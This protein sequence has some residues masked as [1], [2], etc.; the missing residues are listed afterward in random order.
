MGFVS[1]NLNYYK[2]QLLQLESAPAT[3]E[4]IYR[5][6]QLLKILDDLQDEGYTSLCEALEENYQGVSRLKIYLQSNNVAPLFVRNRK[7][8]IISH[9]R[10]TKSNS[11]KQ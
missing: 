6:K 10:K 7:W 1:F 11:P 8:K 9:M 3:D 5:A 2:S 4:S